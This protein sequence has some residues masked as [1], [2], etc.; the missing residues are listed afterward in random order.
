[1]SNPDSGSLGWPEPAPMPKSALLLDRSRI[2][3]ATPTFDFRLS[4]YLIFYFSLCDSVLK[5]VP[6]ELAVVLR[7]LPE[8]ILYLYAFRRLLRRGQ[9]REMPLFWPICACAVVMSLSGA[10]NGSPPILV[11]QGIYTSFRLIAFA[12]I[13]WCA[14]VT[15]E[16]VRYFIN[17]VLC[18]SLVELAVGLLELLMGGDAKTFFA[19]SLDWSG[20]STKPPLELHENDPGYIA[21]TLSNYNHYGMFMSL[22]TVL[23]LAMYGWK[24]SPR[25]LLIACGTALAVV[26]SFSRHS[27]ILLVIGVSMMLFFQRRRCALLRYFKRFTL[28]AVGACLILAF[29]KDLRGSFEE[30]LT[31]LTEAATVN[32]DPRDNMRLFMTVMLTPRFLSDYPLLGQGPFEWPAGTSGGQPDFNSGPVVKAAPQLPGWVTHYLNDV[33]WVAFLGSYGCLGLLAFG[34]L[35]WK[36]GAAAYRLRKSR[37][38]PDCSILGQACLTMMVL[39]I[40]SGLFSQE[41]IARDTIPTF[42]CIVG[43]VFSIST[44]SA[45]G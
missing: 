9:V 16:R 21:G 13:L 19:P 30:R 29:S 42:W 32:G 38:R 33:V 1:M 40:V 12:C 31:T 10:W 41:I 20:G 43:M 35:F 7:Y 5:T 2:S 14:E 28:L 15:P 25:Y 34:S 39:F 3:A 37:H 17:G 6:Y 45:L 27:L 36:I 4:L 8:T 24:R 22:C 11:A 23:A 44:K 18:L 26:F